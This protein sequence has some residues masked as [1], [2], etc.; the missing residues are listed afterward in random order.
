MSAA[1]VVTH[2][3]KRYQSE[4]E[5]KNEGGVSASP[6]LQPIIQTPV[7]I[8]VPYVA[9]RPV[10]MPKPPTTRGQHCNHVT[11]FCLNLKCER[12]RQ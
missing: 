5:S 10:A 9:V 11:H 7:Q 2:A 6:V 3:V 12:G 8:P 1:A 4:L